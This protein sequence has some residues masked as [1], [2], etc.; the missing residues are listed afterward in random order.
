MANNK[1]SKK[2]IV[3]NNK[4]IKQIN[5]NIFMIILVILI[6]ILFIV[7]YKFFYKVTNTY[8]ADSGFIE[9]IYET[10]ASV[11]KSETVIQINSTET[12]VPIVAQNTR[13]TKNE[14]V[15]IFQNAKYKDYIE[16]QKELDNQ[17]SESLKDLPYV[18][19]NDIASID[20]EIKNVIAKTK[21]TS[22]YIKM[23]ELKSTLDELAYKKTVI[24]G[25][26]SPEGSNTRELIK[27][28]AEYEQNNKNN[29]D[30]IKTTISGIINYKLDGLENKFKIEDLDKYN[31]KDFDNLINEYTKQSNNQFGIKIIDNYKGYILVKQPKQN[32]DEYVKLNKQYNITVFN[33][34]ETTI[35]GIL[36]KMVESENEYYFL[37][38]INN[39]LESFIDL[40]QVDIKITWDKKTGIIIPEYAIKK[41]NDVYYTK[42]LKLGEYVEVP[43]KVLKIQDEMCVVTAYST[44]E[45]TQLNLKSKFKIERYDR[46]VGF[47]DNL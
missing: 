21:I 29:T 7:W 46:I 9:T 10:S 2:K 24:I 23:Q 25:N 17:I 35:S 20:N 42:I 19:S 1:T 47:E 11:L 13:A 41:I 22:S 37:F 40:R 38:R 31:V 8:V 36:E 18:Y 6:L 28:R 44:E 15:A 27:K 33:N 16:K 30:N 32:I 12:L 4:I 14:V 3:K 39:G 26:L 43:V 45:L 34:E 5:K